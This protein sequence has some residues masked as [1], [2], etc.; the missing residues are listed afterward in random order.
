MYIVSIVNAFS[1]IEMSRERGGGESEVASYQFVSCCFWICQSCMA[2]LSRTMAML[3][4]V[5]TWERQRAR[6]FCLFLH[7]AFRYE[8]ST[9]SAFGCFFYSK[10]ESG[11]REHSLWC[12]S[13]VLLGMVCP[14]MP[15]VMLWEVEMDK[16]RGRDRAFCLCPWCLWIWR[17]Y[18]DCLWS[19]V[20]ER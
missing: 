1:H 18:C 17:V 9:V 2:C 10:G 6:A 16:E 11:V 5:D 20:G 12:W 14:S 7:S 4:Q 19:F 13:I 8:V 15:L 3:R